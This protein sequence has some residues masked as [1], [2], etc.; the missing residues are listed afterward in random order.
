M[1]TKPIVLSS[2]FTDSIL[3]DKDLGDEVDDV[4]LGNAVAE[5]FWKYEFPAND[6]IDHLIN[7]IQLDIMQSICDNLNIDNDDSKDDELASLSI[8]GFKDVH[9]S[10]SVA[11]AVLREDCG[12]FNTVEFHYRVMK[13]NNLVLHWNDILFKFFWTD[14]FNQEWEYLVYSFH[15]IC[16]VGSCNYCRQ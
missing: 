13:G 11:L 12:D 8:V 9:L 5:I 10:Q 16:V 1:L 2:K 15:Q 7:D 6:G 4:S 14:H 3:F